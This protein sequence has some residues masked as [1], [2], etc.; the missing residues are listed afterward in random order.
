MKQISMSTAFISEICFANDRFS[1]YECLLD[2]S[3]CVLIRKCC[4]KTT[5]TGEEKENEP[6]MRQQWGSQTSSKEG[7][8][9]STSQHV[10]KKGL[11]KADDFGLNLHFISNTYSFFVPCLPAPTTGTQIAMSLRDSRETQALLKES[12]SENELIQRL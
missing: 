9:T 1:I 10:K 8:Q 7:L 2:A 3:E 12:F 11:D 6:T 4:K 5:F